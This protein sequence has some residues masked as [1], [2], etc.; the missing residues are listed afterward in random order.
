VQ[1]PCLT[2]QVT[3]TSGTTSVATI[4]SAGLAT[5][6]STGTSTISAALSGIT[7]TTVMTVT[8]G[9]LAP[10]A[11]R[12]NSQGGYYQYGLWTIGT[13]GYSGTYA[14]AIP[15]ASS[16][17]S[18]RWLFTVPAGTYDF[19]ATWVNGSSDATNAP[20]SIYDGFS[21]LG[22]A[23]ENQQVAPTGGQ[24]GGVSWTKLGTFV[25]TNGRITV[26]L[27]AAAANGDIVADGILIAPASTGGSA[28]SAASSGGGTVSALSNAGL[29]P[30]PE[31]SRAV[32]SHVRG[33][34]RVVD[35][36]SSI[37]S[38]VALGVPRA[39]PAQVAVSQTRDPLSRLDR[40]RAES[41][42]V[43]IWLTHARRK[44]KWRL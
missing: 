8:A 20:Y 32:Q 25:V 16:A 7:G 4:T 24:Y 18:A 5:A 31:Q 42:I 14:Y 22:T 39:T 44:L 13:G 41:A 27:T 11:V 9:A 23:A 3:W 33:G 26:A 38:V 28:K 30:I 40:G 17:A 36:N 34:V 35:P 37:V 6:V 43:R 29:G 2:S 15:A 12:D 1:S 10:I 19:W 21:K